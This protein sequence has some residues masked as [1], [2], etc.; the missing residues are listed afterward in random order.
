VLQAGTREAVFA[1]PASPQVAALLGVA[2]TNTGAAVTANRIA[3]GGAELE[4]RD[5]GLA[6]GMAVAWSIRPEDIALD[7]TGRYEAIVLDSADLGSSRELTLAL[8]GTL[9]L[10]MRTFARV[11]VPVGDPVRIG[12]PPEAISVWPVPEA[13]AA[14]AQPPM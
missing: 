1:A 11:D 6:P 10:T 9:E 13:S 2:N 3:T 7:P 5:V 12:L 4:V 8:E 14:A